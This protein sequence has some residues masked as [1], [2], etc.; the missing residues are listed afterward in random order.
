MEYFGSGFEK[1]KIEGLEEIKLESELYLKENKAGGYSSWYC[2]MAWDEERL[3]CDADLALFDLLFQIDLKN[4]A[5]RTKILSSLCNYGAFGVVKVRA[6]W[7][8]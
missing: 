1:E 2:N 4:G 3:K 8:I 7:K 5:D 6:N